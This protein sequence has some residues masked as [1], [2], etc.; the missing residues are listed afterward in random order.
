MQETFGERL[1]RLR[2]AAGLK[3][4]DLADK[5]AVKQSLISMLESGKRQGGLVQS[6][7]MLRMAEVLDV[8]VEYLLTGQPPRAP[9]RRKPLKSC[10]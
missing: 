5:I 3:Q 2:K 7:T 4:G 1:A 9:R 8:T 6:Q 10:A